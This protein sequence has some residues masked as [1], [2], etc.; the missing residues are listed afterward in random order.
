MPDEYHVLGSV[1]AAQRQVGNAVPSALAEVIGW[2]IRRRLLGDAHLGPV[3]PSL[4]PEQRRDI[5]PPEPVLPV[6]QKYLHLRGEHEA[7]PGTGKGNRA[8]LRATEG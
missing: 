7:H 6:A 2:E 1:S 5:P 3:D 8:S 4:I